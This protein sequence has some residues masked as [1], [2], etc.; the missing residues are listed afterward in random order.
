M[1]K[2]IQRF[3]PRITVG[4]FANLAVLRPLRYKNYRKGLKG[5]VKGDK[6]LYRNSFCRHGYII[7]LSQQNP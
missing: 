4:D 1:V 2:F 6:T 7:R 5:Y 3:L